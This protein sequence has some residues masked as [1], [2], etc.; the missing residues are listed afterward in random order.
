MPNTDYIVDALRKISLFGGLEDEILTSIA[1]HC[2]PVSRKAGQSI[3]EAKE[4]TRDVYFL[5]A[6]RAR[7]LNYSA[8]G[9]A[10]ILSDIEQGG[11][12]GEMA[13]ID[14]LDRSAS[15]ETLDDCE[16]LL[17]PERDFLLL[18]HDEPEITHTFLRHF[19]AELRVMSQRLF[20]FRTLAVQNRIHAELLRLARLTETTEQSVSLQPAPTLA[21]IAD[22]VST[23]RE[24]V[25]REI[26]RLTKAG[27]LKRGGN[28]LVIADVQRLE[29]MVREAT[30]S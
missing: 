11:F 26:S 1:S 18:L 25:S 16:L 7:V 27:L 19:V 14:G 29:A 9:K 22:R 6:G 30:D 17:L 4:D 24:A 15:V 8:D 10:V 20:E 5:V 3:V 13:A 2:R 21:E 28:A 12:F 23:H